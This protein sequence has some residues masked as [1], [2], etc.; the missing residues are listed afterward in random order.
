MPVML[1]LAAMLCSVAIISCKDD[2]GDNTPATDFTA[3]NATIATAEARLEDTEEGKNDGQYPAAARTTLQTA[4]TAAK[5]VVSTAGTTQVMA[6][7]ANTS[8][9]LAIEAYDAAEITPIAAEALVGHWSFDEGDGDVAGDASGN[10]F[11]GDFVA[12]PQWDEENGGGMPEWVAD[13]T[14]A[15]GKAVHFGPD[16]GSVEIPYNTKLNPASMTIAL[17]LKADEIFSGNRFMGLHSWVGYK[18]QLQEANRPFLTVATA[19]ATYDRD[20]EQNLP[21]D[22]WHHVVATFGGGKTIFYVDGELIKTWE[23]TPGDAK[24]IQAK[25]YNLVFGQDFPTDKYCACNG[26]NFGTEGHAE[27]QVIPLA[28][29]GHFKGS[30]DEVRIYNTVLTESQV[31]SLYDREKPE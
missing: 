30:I 24:S 27:Y 11:D 2:D 13:R 4:I 7:N 19:S 9:G 26:D 6:D 18:F 25:P 10:G 17:W 5:L 15:A 29:G 22:S 12:G 28:W 21:I 31:G 16:G 20:S 8:L 14:G 3:L 1:F 23:D